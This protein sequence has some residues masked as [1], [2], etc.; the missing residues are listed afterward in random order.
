MTTVVFK[1]VRYGLNADKPSKTA[2]SIAVDTPTQTARLLNRKKT[3][4]VLSADRCLTIGFITPHTT[5]GRNAVLVAQSARY[6]RVCSYNVTTRLVELELGPTVGDVTTSLPAVS[7]IRV[8]WKDLSLPK[9]DAA[10]DAGASSQPEIYGLYIVSTSQ[11]RAG[12]VNTVSL[13]FSNFA[14]MAEAYCCLVSVLLPELPVAPPPQG[15]PPIAWRDSLATEQPARSHLLV[16]RRSVSRINSRES[17]SGTS[18]CDTGSLSAR[19]I[20]T[21]QRPSLATLVSVSSADDLTPLSRQAPSS[22]GSA[23]SQYSTATTTSAIE[24]Q[25][26]RL[27]TYL[28][29]LGRCAAEERLLDLGRPGTCILRCTN[30]SNHIALTTYTEHRELLHQTV[31]TVIVHSSDH[32]SDTLDSQLANLARLCV[33]TPRRKL[34]SVLGFDAWWTEGG[35]DRAEP[36][37]VP[38]VGQQSCV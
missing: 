20:S 32:C 4:Q 19:S 14:D 10:V 31:N 12:T 29:D 27:K 25:Q 6:A 7:V 13:Q 17:D 22:C 33:T 36:V 5:I 35:S 2:L 34:L 8:P 30:G 16:P 18:S 21:R 23:A 24:L 15:I 38:V 28:T 26:H 11:S 9:L 1:D 3:I 37:V